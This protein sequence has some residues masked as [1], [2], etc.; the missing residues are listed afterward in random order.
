MSDLS[1]VS[2]NS[3][4]TDNEVRISVLLAF[5]QR[6]EYIMCLCLAV[7]VYEK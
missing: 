2:E 3:L 1:E 7:K 5:N 4:E 6:M